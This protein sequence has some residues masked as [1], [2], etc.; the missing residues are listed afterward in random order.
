MEKS[1]MGALFVLIKRPTDQETGMV[2]KAAV[3]TVGEV[4]ED[5]VAVGM[6]MAPGTAEIHILAVATLTV[7]V[8]AETTTGV[9]TEAVEITEVQV[10]EIMVPAEITAVVGTMPV[11]ITMEEVVITAAAVTTVPGPITVPPGKVTPPGSMDLAAMVTA[12]AAGHM[13][14]L[15][16]TIERLRIAPQAMTGHLG[17]LV[18][19]KRALQ[20]VLGEMVENHLSRLKD[21]LA[22]C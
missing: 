6:A 2:I 18:A 12:S 19:T 17:I 7:E 20:V 5:T 10:V 21:C 9:D 13:I 4:A 14:V 1:S 8:A 3:D 22:D 11:E 16:L 15:Q